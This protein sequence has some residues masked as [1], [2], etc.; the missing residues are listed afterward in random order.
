MANILV[1]YH[2][3]SYP[4]RNTITDHLYAFARYSGHQCFYFNVGTRNFPEYLLRVH[5]DLI[6][7][8]TVFLSVRWNPANFQ[9]MVRQIQP[10]KKLSGIR[11]ALPQDEFLQTDLLEEFFRE[12]GVDHIFSVMPPDEWDTIYPNIDKERTHIHP[13]LTGYLDDSTIARIRHLERVTPPDRPIDI[14]YRAWHAAFWLGR[15]GLLKSLIA[16]RFREQAS[17]YGLRVDISTRDEDVMLGDRWLEY[18]LKCKYTIGVEG[19]SSMLDRDGTLKE[20]TEAY[21]REHP[22][23]GFE[24]VEAHCFPGLDKMVNLVA[25]S[26]RHLEACVTKTCQILVE[27]NYNGILQLGRHYIPLKPDF[28]N[29]DEVLELVKA[30]T[31][32]EQIV[33]QTYQDIVESGRYTNRSFVEQILQ[34]CQITNSSGSTEAEIEWF[35]RNHLDEKIGWVKVRTYFTARQRLIRYLQRNHSSEQIDRWRRWYN[36]LRSAR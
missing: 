10:L 2:A 33:E 14:G 18:L 15:H 26:P 30:D 9:R 28:S 35:R 12:F 20:C 13:I 8:H 36:R 11:I 23:A 6:I 21:L 16:E 27:G 29:L 31:I 4:L 7:F 1:I 32:R 22:Q 5:F 24:E 34:Q 25:I 19:G 3:N 17:R